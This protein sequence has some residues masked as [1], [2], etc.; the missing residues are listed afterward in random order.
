MCGW[1]IIAIVPISA[2]VFANIACVSFRE[3]A[4]RSAP[5]AISVGPPWSAGPDRRFQRANGGTSALRIMSSRPAQRQ[6]DVR[7]DPRPRQHGK[8]PVVDLDP[9]RRRQP[10]LPQMHGHVREDPLD[11][12]TGGG[13]RPAGQGHVVSRRRSGRSRRASVGRNPVLIAGRA[14]RETERLGPRPKRSREG[15][16]IA[17]FWTST[18]HGRGRKSSRRMRSREPS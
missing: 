2:S 10:Q 5:I 17:S 7:H 12:V 18:T 16:W 15:H 3:A 4:I 9:V 6:M 13:E 14:R 11:E 8:E 1:T